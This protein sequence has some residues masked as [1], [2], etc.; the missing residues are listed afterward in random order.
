MARAEIDP[1]LVK[2]QHLATT[3]VI[4]ERALFSIIANPFLLVYNEFLALT[5]PKMIDG[6]G[7]QR[8]ILA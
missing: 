1:S 2:R 3:R 6:K 5:K 4:S 8:P 7:M